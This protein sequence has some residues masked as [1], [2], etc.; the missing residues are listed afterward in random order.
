[1]S[2]K[3][4]RTGDQCHLIMIWANKFTQAS[5]KQTSSFRDLCGNIEDSYYWCWVFYCSV[6]HWLLFLHLWPRTWQEV[7]KWFK[8]GLA[9]AHSL[10]VQSIMVQKALGQEWILAVV[11]DWRGCLCTF[12]WP[13]KQI[14]AE[15]RGMLA[16]VWL[17]FLIFSLFHPCPDTT[18]EQGMSFLP[19]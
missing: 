12:Q 17:S 8:G 13:R 9:L 16:S 10:Q 4:L 7:F 11:V 14:A 19:Q 15:H 5:Q 6:E 2:E 18:Q 1:M 3:L